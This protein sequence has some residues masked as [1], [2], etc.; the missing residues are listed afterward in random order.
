MARLLLSKSTLLKEKK[1]LESFLRFL[2]SLEMK[3]Q[4]LMVAVKKSQ[5]Q[6]DSLRQQAAANEKIISDEVPM[7]AIE[8]IDLQNLCQVKS[9]QQQR[10]N[11]VGVWLLD[12]SSIEFELAEISILAKPHWVDF[13][14][15]KLKQDIEI[16][17]MLDIE[18]FNL[19]RLKQELKKVTQRVNLFD[20]V[21]IPEARKNMRK[22]QLFLDD[23]DREMVVTSKLSKTLREKKRIKNQALRTDGLANDQASKSES[24]SNSNMTR[25]E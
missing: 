13:L 25:F 15:A 9:V 14:Q 20:K 7:L 18:F 6:S 10:K 22:I 23:K 21:L 8:G 4:Q 2:P 3:R 11:V 17:I 19:N 16:S 5:I 12:I 1:R 24:S